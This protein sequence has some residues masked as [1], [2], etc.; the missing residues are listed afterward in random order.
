MGN[1]CWTG[2]G[3]ETEERSCKLSVI[4]PAYN[5]EKHIVRCMDSILKQRVGFSYE[6]NVVNDGS[7]DAT[8]LRLLQILF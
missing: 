2:V 6:V 4:V 5:V 7:T 3:F 8:V 1:S